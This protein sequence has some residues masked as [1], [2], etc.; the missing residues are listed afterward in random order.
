MDN[1]QQAEESVSRQREKFLSVCAQLEDKQLQ[2]QAKGEPMNPTA[3]FPVNLLS[4]VEAVIEA[5]DHVLSLC[6]NVGE[7]TGSV[8]SSLARK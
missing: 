1:L 6:G 3:P 2:Y 7:A 5:T 4:T 8:H